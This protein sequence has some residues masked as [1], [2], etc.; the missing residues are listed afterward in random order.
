M[1]C[2]TQTDSCFNLLLPRF[3]L[4][5]LYSCTPYTDQL[6]EEGNTA[7]PSTSS[8]SEG[9]STKK[10]TMSST[11]F[12]SVSSSGE[13]STQEETSVEE[14]SILAGSCRSESVLASIYGTTTSAAGSKD[15]RTSAGTGKGKEKF[16]SDCECAEHEDVYKAGEE[17]A[18]S[19]DSEVEWEDVEPI[20]QLEGMLKEMPEELL[21]LQQHGFASHNFS[22]PVEVTSQFEVI[23]DEDNSNILATLRESRQMLTCIFLPTI[24]KWMEVYKC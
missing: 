22:I 12:A 20:A 21:E 14:E 3:D 7:V 2:L 4:P 18:H 11:S 13:C 24:I 6:P 5:D 10:R 16:T 15:G 8:R 19:S 9:C 23:E 1:D 17:E